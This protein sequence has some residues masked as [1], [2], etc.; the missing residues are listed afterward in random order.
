MTMSMAGHDVLAACV[1]MTTL[2]SACFSFEPDMARRARIASS[3]SMK[4]VCV[5]CHWAA[6]GGGLTR[7]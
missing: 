6:P 3:S 1:D 4:L 5:L 2:R 7:M